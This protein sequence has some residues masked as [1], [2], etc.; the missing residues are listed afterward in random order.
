MEHSSVELILFSA[1]KE[2]AFPVLTSASVVYKCD[3]RHLQLDRFKSSLT[4]MVVDDSSGGM[5]ITI[6]FVFLKCYSTPTFLKIL[7]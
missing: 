4:V 3:L 2:M 7:S 5:L 1:L 6:T